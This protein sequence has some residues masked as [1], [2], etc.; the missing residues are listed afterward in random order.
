MVFRQARE[1][2][3]DR[4]GFARVEDGLGD[5]QRLD[6]LSRVRQQRPEARL[7]VAGILEFGLV[8]D[9]E[10]GVEAATR[11]EVLGGGAADL[12]V[13]Q[14]HERDDVSERGP[15]RRNVDEDG[16]HVA[17]PQGGLRVRPVRQDGQDAVRRGAVGQDAFEPR[18]VA[19]E[20]DR[21]VRL[22]VDEAEDAREVVALGRAEVTDDDGDRLVLGVRRCHVDAAYCTKTLF[23]RQRRGDWME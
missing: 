6:G 16:R 5:A 7:P 20:L 8:D 10:V 17:E 11:E 13:V 15:V 18:T 22:R 14:P 1:R 2:P 12:A 9:A 23:L 21:P 4:L 19:V 3:P